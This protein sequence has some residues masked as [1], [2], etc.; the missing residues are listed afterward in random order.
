MNPFETLCVKRNSPITTAK[1]M[2]ETMLYCTICNEDCHFLYFHR[3]NYIIHAN[4]K[5][6][7]P[8]VLRGME[9]EKV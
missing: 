8:C 9:L 6:K 2:N 1:T 5:T 4:Y 7:I 3:L